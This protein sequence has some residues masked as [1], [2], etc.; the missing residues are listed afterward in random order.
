M[1]IT[2]KPI[3]RIHSPYKT[4][5]DMPIQGTFKPGIEAWVQLYKP[6]HPGLADL[7]GF[8]HAIL[9]Y[10]FHKSKTCRMTAQPF[11]EDQPHG[12]FAIRSPHRP[13]HIG[14]SIVKIT[15][16]EPGRLYFQEV[17]MLDKTP[18][19]DIKPYVKYFDSRENTTAGWVEKHFTNNTTPTRTILK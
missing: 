13:N 16:I 6:Y 14:L 10:Y 3:G 8:S 18:V 7:D 17:D 2:M 5:K 19:L 15:R 11:L 4:P 12:I 9:L 1:Q